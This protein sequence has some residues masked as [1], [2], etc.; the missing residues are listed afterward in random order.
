MDDRGQ[1]KK[2]VLNAG[3]GQM[4]M[5]GKRRGG[6]NA[7]DRKTQKLFGKESFERKTLKKNQM[8]H[9]FSDKIKRNI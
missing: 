8:M 6:A 5:R 9:M 4:K 2:N 7:H 1:Y 3:N